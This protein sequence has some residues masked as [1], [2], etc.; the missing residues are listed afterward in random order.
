MAEKQALAPEGGRLQ[1]SRPGVYVPPGIRWE[2]PFD[3]KA[4]LATACDK[5]GG[6][7]EPCDSN[8]AS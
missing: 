7:G 8:P 1:P 6:T 5:L 3:V 2:E 4:N